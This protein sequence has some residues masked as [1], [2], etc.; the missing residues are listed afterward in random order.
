MFEIEYERMEKLIRD[1]IAI[2]EELEKM[3]QQDAKDNGFRIRS[4][5]RDMA[6][7]FTNHLGING[8]V[9][10]FYQESFDKITS[11]R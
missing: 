1:A 2:A 9:R 11:R 7:V 3:P 8:S 6:R 10:S 5:A 4:Y